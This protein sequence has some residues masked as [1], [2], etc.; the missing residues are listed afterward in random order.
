MKIYLIIENKCY[1]DPDDNPQCCPC[2]WKAF[3]E[4]STAIECTKAF[5]DEVVATREG[6]EKLD[7]E[8]DVVEEDTTYWGDIF[9]EAIGAYAKNWYEPTVFSIR[10]MEVLE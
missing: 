5:I 4:K 9:K 8:E 7:I 1:L 2:V 3:A 6:V 10:E